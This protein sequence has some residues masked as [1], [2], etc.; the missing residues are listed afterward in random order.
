[1]V[2]GDSNSG[3]DPRREYGRRELKKKPIPDL[4]MAYAKKWKAIWAGPFGKNRI[5]GRG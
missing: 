5:S 3:E 4:T 1:M 2:S